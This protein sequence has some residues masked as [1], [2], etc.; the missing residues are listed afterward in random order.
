VNTPKP[1]VERREEQ[2]GT[3]ITY[4]Y[5]TFSSDVNSDDLVWHRDRESRQVHI[6]SGKGWKLQKDDKLPQELLPGT[7][8]YIH[9][10]LYHRLIK[11]DGDLLIR[12]KEL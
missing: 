3:G 9:K 1:Y 7:D 2:C 6:L 12:I 8:V 11:G 4:I 10:G 5:R